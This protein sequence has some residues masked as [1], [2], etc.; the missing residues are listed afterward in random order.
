MDLTKARVR[1]PGHVRFTVI[2]NEAVIIDA[3]T[4][5][6]LGLDEVGTRILQIISETGSTEHVI[7]TLLHEYQI[8]EETLRSDVINLVEEF[9]AK[10]IV[11][12]EE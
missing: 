11:E 1:I 5:M 3:N 9:R 7:E 6:Y 8:S 2:D 10:G 12:V 4:G